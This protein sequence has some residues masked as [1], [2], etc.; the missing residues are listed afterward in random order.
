MI[1]KVK[2]ISKF[3]SRTYSTVMKKVIITLLAISILAVTACSR[4]TCPT[5]AKAKIVKEVN[6]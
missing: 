4:K 5:Y 1:I 3:V 2:K 6:S